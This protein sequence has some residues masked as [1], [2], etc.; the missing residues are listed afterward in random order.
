MDYLFGTTVK[1]LRG[2]SDTDVF[3]PSLKETHERY[4]SVMWLL[5]GGDYTEIWKATDVEIVED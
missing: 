3:V 1:G 2:I 5:D 4:S